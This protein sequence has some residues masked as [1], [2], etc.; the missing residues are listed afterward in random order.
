MKFCLIY[1]SATLFSISLCAQ[2][3]DIEVI[4]ASG[5]DGS[6]ATHQLSWTIGE[7]IIETHIGAANIVTQGFHQTNLV[8]TDVTEV[9]PLNLELVIY[10]NP[11]V[12]QLNLLIENPENIPLNYLLYDE[13][14]RVLKQDF[15]NTSLSMISM[16]NLARANYVLVIQS[17]EHIMKAFKVIKMN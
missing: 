10:P 12:N 14:G 2:S 15:I 17:E 4:S 5:N 11:V 8:V 13:L 16:E 6:S 1:F 3:I 9:K 7:P